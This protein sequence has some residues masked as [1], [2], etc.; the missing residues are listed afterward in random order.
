MSTP[1]PLGRSP[2]EQAL[3]HATG[4]FY[5]VVS[6]PSRDALDVAVF[7]TPVTVVVATEFVQDALSTA[8]TPA[9][10]LGESAGSL[11]WATIG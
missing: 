7:V 6:P 1:F 11:L 2:F 5:R 10:V 3:D 8:T 9:A 4:I